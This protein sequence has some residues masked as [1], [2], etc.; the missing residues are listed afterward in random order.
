[1]HKVFLF[2]CKPGKDDINDP[3]YHQSP[4]SSA[5]SRWLNESQYKPDYPIWLNRNESEPIW[6]QR[7][8]TNDRLRTDLVNKEEVWRET[9]LGAE[10]LHTYDEIEGKSVQDK[11]SNT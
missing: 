10:I 7:D 4:Y 1:M 9:V 6:V 3:V 11:K 8:D 5:D 2:Q